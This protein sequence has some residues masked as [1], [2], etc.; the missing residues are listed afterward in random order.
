MILLNVQITGTSSALKRVTG[1]R[2]TAKLQ[3]VIDR[4]YAGSNLQLC[5]KIL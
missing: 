1:Y 3:V 4:P 2:V 5:L